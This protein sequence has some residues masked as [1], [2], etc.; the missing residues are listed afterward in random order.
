MA[1]TTR[2]KI[3]SEGLAIASQAGLEGVTLGVLANQ[4]GMSKSGLF[5]H[6]HSKEAVQVSLL[7]RSQAMGAPVIIE[8]AMRQPPGLPRLKTLV[9]NWFGWAARAGLPGGCPVAAAMFEYDDME[10]PV[11]DKI[12]ELE[13]AWRSFLADCVR[14]CVERGQLRRNLDVDQFVWEL[15]GIYLA[16]HTMSRFVRSLDA[17]QRADKAFNALLGRSGKQ[18]AKSQ[19]AKK[20]I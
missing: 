7:E 2:E 8:P 10:G 17:D 9:R 6:F 4:V 15:C 5:A 3:L 12:R 13:A 11:R 1:S 20:R 14:E 18:Q 16:H 19:Q